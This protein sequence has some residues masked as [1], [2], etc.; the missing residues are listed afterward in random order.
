MG[1]L[2]LWYRLARIAIVGR[3][4]IAPGGGQNPLEPA[5]LGCAIAV[6]PHTGNFTDH[7]ALLRDAGGLVEVAD[8]A[9]LV[10]FVRAMLDNPDRR[11]LLGQRAAAAV[12]RHADLPG[13]T[14]E[15]LLSL[16]PVPAWCRQ[17]GLASSDFR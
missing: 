7:V 8:E 3:S 1:E 13:L 5:R 17:S 11:R 6:G 9:A 10:R 15:V 12:Q 2:G 16:L 4:L 14:A